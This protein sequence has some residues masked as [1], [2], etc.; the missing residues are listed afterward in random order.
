VLRQSES[1]GE[2]EGGIRWTR[3]WGTT[4]SRG[5]GQCERGFNKANVDNTSS[6]KINGGLGTV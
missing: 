6:A 2:Y 1:E 4:T 5:R 3:S